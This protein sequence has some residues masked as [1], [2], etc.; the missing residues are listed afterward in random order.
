QDHVGYQTLVRFTVAFLRGSGDRGPIREPV[1]REHDLADDLAGREVADQALRA[2]VAER[3]IERAPY[4]ARNAERAAIGLRNV[5]ALHLM[6]SPLD[7]SG[8][9]DEPLARAVDGNLLGDDFL[10]RQGEPLRERHAQLPR[11]GG[12]LVEVLRAAHV[13]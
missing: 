1:A 6:G 3:A 5:D 2:G 9:P 7:L 4:L 12:H 13:E 10:A 11:Q 8:K